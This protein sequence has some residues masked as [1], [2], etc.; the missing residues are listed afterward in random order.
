MQQALENSM[1]G[2]SEEEL[3]QVCGGVTQ[4]EVDS[5][6]PFVIVDPPILVPV[7]W[8]L[9]HPTRGP[10]YTPPTDPNDPRSFI[11]F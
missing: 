2:L 3:A 4:K 11:F 7:G 10:V 5:L 9:N 8:G 1:D 6:L